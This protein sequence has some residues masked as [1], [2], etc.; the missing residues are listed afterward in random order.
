MPSVMLVFVLKATMSIDGIRCLK[1][2]HPFYL[3]DIFVRFYPI[4]LIF[5]RNMPQSL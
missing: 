1:K 4:L 3:C 2:R 5:G